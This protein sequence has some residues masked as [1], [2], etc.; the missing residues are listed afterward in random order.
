VLKDFQDKNDARVA[1]D[2]FGDLVYLAS[3]AVN[4]QMAQER[5]PEVR[6]MDTRDHSACAKR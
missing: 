2:H 4:L 6:F 5:F 3:S 1:R